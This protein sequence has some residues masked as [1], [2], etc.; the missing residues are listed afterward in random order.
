ML[1]T[2]QVNFD[3]RSAQISTHTS[4]TA[5]S[6]NIFPNANM[7]FTAVLGFVITQEEYI[8]YADQHNLAIGLPLGIRFQAVRDDWRRRLKHAGLP[9]VTYT[10]RRELGSENIA[11]CFV[12]GNNQKGTFVKAWKKGLAKEMLD[13]AR[14]ALGVEGTP[15]WY[16]VIKL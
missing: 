11:E 13:K 16:N 3:G 12:F 7:N 2:N 4:T 6:P 8:K 14:V 10:V 9:F 15:Q 1:A 5:A